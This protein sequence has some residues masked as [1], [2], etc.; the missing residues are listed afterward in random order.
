M[1]AHLRGGK[2]STVRA[3]PPDR[4]RTLQPH[5]IIRP[6]VQFIHRLAVLSLIAGLAP[7]D[8]VAQHQERSQIPEK[9][10]WNLAEIYPDDQAWRAAKDKLAA[11]LPT[12]RAVQGNAR[13][14]ATEARRRAGAG[15]PHLEGLLP[16][17]GLRQ[18]DVRPGHAGQHLPGHAAG[19]GRR[20]APTSAP[21]LAFVEPEILKI[22]PATIDKFI[23]AEPRLKVYT[24]LPA[25]HSSPP[26]THVEPTRKKNPGE[27]L[28][29]GGRS[30]EHL[31]HPVRCGLPVSDGHAQ[32]RQERQAR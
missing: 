4:R 21:N 26:R 27:L 6:M 3:R 29:R 10:R 22:D 17:R 30:V 25:R 18:H 24:L 7:A 9:Y 20:L 23:A 32:R 28:G 12:I 1:I 8:L 14:V 19:D 13:I 31:R 2:S 16:D 15:Q 5:T 11:E